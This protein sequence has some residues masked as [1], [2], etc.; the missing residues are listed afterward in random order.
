GINVE[1]LGETD[2]F[3]LHAEGG[4]ACVQVFFYRGGQNFGNRAYYPAHA[5]DVDPAEVLAA[6]VTQFYD[7]R[8]A[9]PL[10]LLSHAIG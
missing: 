9:P 4:E 2:V 7:S 6:F 8:P 10:L 3:A 1:G 5:R